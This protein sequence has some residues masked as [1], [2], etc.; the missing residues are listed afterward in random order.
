MKSI[1][2]SAPIQIKTSVPGF[3]KLNDHLVK[4]LKAGFSGFATI[5]LIIFFIKLLSY[6]ISNEEFRMDFLDLLLAGLG[7]FLQM[8]HTIIINFKK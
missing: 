6:I 2:Q 8:T 4:T 5:L 3:G 7:F 1:I